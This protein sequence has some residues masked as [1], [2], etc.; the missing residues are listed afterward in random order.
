[1]TNGH[2]IPF[3]NNSLE[4]AGNNKAGKKFSEGEGWA[5]ELRYNGFSSH[6]GTVFLEMI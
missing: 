4:S 2:I 5:V 3:K 1:M 6:G